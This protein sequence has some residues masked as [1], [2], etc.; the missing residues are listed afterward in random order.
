MTFRDLLSKPW[1]FVLFINTR[2]FSLEPE[3][4]FPLARRTFSLK[5]PKRPVCVEGTGLP[6]SSKRFVLPPHRCCQQPKIMDVD[7]E[8]NETQPV[9]SGHSSLSS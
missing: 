8:A 4:T 7:D 6:L 1:W 9:S 5:C 3:H 2:C